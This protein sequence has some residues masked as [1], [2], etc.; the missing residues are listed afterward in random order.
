MGVFER[1]LSL[2]VALC[3]AA[4]VGLG[5]VMPELFD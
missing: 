2:W 4:G 3:I 1:L 5:I